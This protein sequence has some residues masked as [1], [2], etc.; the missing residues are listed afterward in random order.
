MTSTMSMNARHQRV[1]QLVQQDPRVRDCAHTFNEAQADISQWHANN[2]TLTATKGALTELDELITYSEFCLEDLKCARRRAYE[3]VMAQYP[4]VWDTTCPDPFVTDAQSEKEPLAETEE[5]ATTPANN[6]TVTVIPGDKIMEILNR[7]QAVYEVTIN[8][9][10]AWGM[11]AE[12]QR[13]R[14]QAVQRIRTQFQRLIDQA[15][16]ARNA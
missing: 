2:D 3:Q 11:N 7:E 5:I 14:L 15:K 13:E 6:D 10:D 9:C 1:R 8:V 4:R 12:P 16:E